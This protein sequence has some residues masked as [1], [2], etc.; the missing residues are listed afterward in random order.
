MKS[1]DMLK[2]VRWI[3]IVGWLSSGKCIKCLVP[4]ENQHKYQTQKGEGATSVL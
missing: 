4:N 2:V 1:R 3:K